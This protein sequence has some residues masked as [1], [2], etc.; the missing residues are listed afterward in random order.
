[1]DLEH[2]VRKLTES[3]EELQRTIHYSTKKVD[4]IRRKSG[5]TRSAV[6]QQ[7]RAAKQKI[8][9]FAAEQFRSFFTAAEP[10][11]EASYRQLL[12]HV[13]AEYARLQ[14]SDLAIRRLV[15]AAPKQSTVDAVAHMAGV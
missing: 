12:T 3:N 10:L 2:L 1:M 15:G 4:S 13:K 14:N 7:L 6:K 5:G 9:E 11:N 8:F